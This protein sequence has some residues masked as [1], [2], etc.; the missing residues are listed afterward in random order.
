[1]EDRL[2]LETGRLPLV[3][4]HAVGEHIEAGFLLL[5]G[6]ELDGVLVGDAQ[7]VAAVHRLVKGAEDPPLQPVWAREGRDSRD[8]QQYFLSADLH[9]SSESNATCG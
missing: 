2:E 4:L 8:R 5:A 7:V 6:A 3:V 9:G 1:V